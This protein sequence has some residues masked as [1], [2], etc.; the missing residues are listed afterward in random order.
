MHAAVV[1]LAGTISEEV[2]MCELARSVAELALLRLQ[3]GLLGNGPDA[4]PANEVEAGR[5]V[6]KEVLL[7]F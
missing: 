5:D 2:D 1:L 4:G 6:A 7:T 3:F